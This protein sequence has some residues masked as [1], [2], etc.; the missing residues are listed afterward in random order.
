[1]DWC[2]IVID[3]SMK[4]SAYILVINPFMTEGK[5]NPNAWTQFCNLMRCALI[6]AVRVNG[7]ITP[8]VLLCSADGEPPLLAEYKDWKNSNGRHPEVTSLAPHSGITAHWFLHSLPK[9]FYMWVQLLII[10]KIVFF[11]THTALWMDL[12]M[13]TCLYCLWSRGGWQG[14][15]L[16]AWTAWWMI[17]TFI[18]LYRSLWSF[19]KVNEHCTWIG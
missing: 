7:L 6:N 4:T 15:K 13:S 12:L 14:T 3:V 18:W 11:M 17:N 16:T 2:N 9:A 10:I 8:A 19:L 1:M 5:I